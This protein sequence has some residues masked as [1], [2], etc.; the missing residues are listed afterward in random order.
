MNY[1]EYAWRTALC[2]GQV[3]FYDLVREDLIMSFGY[4]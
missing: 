4:T 1:S 3:H 2:L